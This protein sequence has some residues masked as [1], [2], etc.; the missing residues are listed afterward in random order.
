MKKSIE[1]VRSGQINE[2]GPRFN[3]NSESEFLSKLKKYVMLDRDIQVLDLQINTAINKAMNGSDPEL[4]ISLDDSKLNL[5]TYQQIIHKVYSVIRYKVYQEIQRKI[6]ANKST[7]M[8]QKSNPN[9]NDSVLSTIS[10]AI[11]EE[12]LTNMIKDLDIETI[13]REVF[14]LYSIQYGLDTTL[15]LRKVQVLEAEDEVFQNYL[16]CLKE[17]H[18]QFLSYVFQGNVFGKMQ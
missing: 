14:Q 18:D 11:G 9:M 13:N 12:D 10:L 5:D 3:C 1:K 7:Y 8:R 2:W 17:A 6:R 16:E 4:V 15:A